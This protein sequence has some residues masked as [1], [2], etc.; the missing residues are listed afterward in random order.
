M[1]TS[2]LNEIRLRDTFG[3]KIR[4]I[5]VFLVA[6][7]R[8]HQPI[9]K[10]II[11]TVI[12]L[13]FFVGFW[14]PEAWQPYL[15]LKQS[16]FAAICIASY[17]LTSAVLVWLSEWDNFRRTTVWI[18]SNLL[19]LVAFAYFL[20]TSYRMV[21][22]L[23]VSVHTGW[24]FIILAGLILLVNYNLFGKNRRFQWLLLA[25]VIL[26]A[27]QGYAFL[28]LTD[29]YITDGI[30]F[31]S[32]WLQI[33]FNLHPFFWL[34]LSALAI[35]A[36]TILS[37]QLPKK[38]DYLRFFGLFAYLM[39]QGILLIYLVNFI[40]VTL[41][42]TYWNLALMALVYWD[43]LD[44]PVRTISQK[45]EDDRFYARLAVSTVYHGLL[46]II[47]AL[48]PQIQQLLR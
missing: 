41:Y 3:Q 24:I 8:T 48:A 2:L 30:S 22:I 43:Y 36:I 39:V 25:Q 12:S 40:D 42:L 26:F 5:W 32:D 17:L 15:G 44:G 33:F 13:V 28:S 7:A 10:A 47:I 21:S 4:K 45:L 18:Q 9:L 29:T 19:M 35:A 38:Q 23:G 27:L 46:M 11:L 37:L 31:T 6:Q 20:R 1:Q 16:W 34:T 14:Y